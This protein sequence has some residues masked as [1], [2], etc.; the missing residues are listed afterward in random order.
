VS[1]ETLCLGEAKALLPWFR[2]PEVTDLFVNGT[3]SVSVDKGKGLELQRSPF[4]A[5]GLRDF[6]ERLLLPLGRRVDAAQPFLDGRVGEDARF[7]V[8]FPPAAEEAPHL[9]FRLFRRAALAPLS[10]FG[11]VTPLLEG[12]RAGQNWILCGATGSGKTTLLSRLLDEAA[13]TQRVLVVEESRE[14]RLEHPHLI[15]LEG[16]PAGPEGVGEV[17]LR[18][19]LRQALRMRPDRLVLGECRG[20]EA[21]DLI[22]AMNTGHRG[23]ISTLHANS[24]RDGLRRLE[25]LVLLG[26]RGASLS[27]VRE[28]V[29]GA[30]QGVAFLERRG[31]ERR[32]AELVEVRG[33]EG[34]VYRIT[35]KYPLLGASRRAAPSPLALDGKVCEFTPL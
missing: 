6:V 23:S 17:T 32:I 1:W 29:A 7:H 10:S 28:W 13:G 8:L 3:R 9:S 22:Q 11:M 30:V 16:R 34:E 31:P 15:S 27:A 5:E 35:P 25:S 33:L 24:C 4:T 21:F 19:L 2:D 18:T 20:E 12:L 14:I 26:S